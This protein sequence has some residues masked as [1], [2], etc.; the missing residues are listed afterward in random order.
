MS[1]LYPIA[2]WLSA[3][4]PAVV[5]LYLRRQ[6]RRTQTVSTLLFWQRAVAAQ[7]HQRFLGRLRQPWS[8][9][10][11][12]LILVLLILAAAQLR[13]GGTFEPRSTV[14]VI[15][16]RARMQA[17]DAFSKAR[18][19]ALAIASGAGPGEEVA[20]IGAEISPAIVSS[21]SRDPKHLR[22]ELNKLTPSDGGGDFSQ[23]VR[24]AQNLLRS[25]P[26]K[27]RLVAISDRTDP[28]LIDAEQIAVGKSGSNL[29]IIAS[30]A[31]PVPSSPQTWEIFTRVAN[32]SDTA[33]T[34]EISLSLDGRLFDARRLPLEAGATASFVTALPLRDTGKGLVETVLKSSDAMKLDD[35]A[36]T[37]LPV[38]GKTQVLLITTG[39][40]FLESALKA[41]PAINLEV[42]APETWKPSMA[43]AFAVVAFDGRP[44]ADVP[45]DSQTGFL[46][47][48][49]S[50]SG[51]A[52]K[53]TQTGEVEI[54]DPKSPLLRNTNLSSALFPTS[55]RL[56]AIGGT[57]WRV[58]DV[59]KGPAGP[60][61]TT[62]ERPGG[63][64]RRAIFSFGVA[65]SDLPLK[66]A[67]PILLSNTV[68]WLAGNEKDASRDI[69]AG[70]VLKMEE[71]LAV[72]QTGSS[73]TLRKA[74]F[75]EVTDKD[76][77]R[78][79]AV[80]ISAPEESDFRL[81]SASGGVKAPMLPMA[82][83]LW[84]WMALAAFALLLAEWWL[85]H[86][87]VTE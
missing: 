1:F 56:P 39:N 43:N 30:S 67:F 72:A 65:D 7:P 32:F 75:Y 14:V 2:L 31:R 42:L 10:L 74:G 50:P 16:S 33:E 18:D 17:G 9:L 37:A 84:Q 29:A 59:V 44:P 85:H 87:R 82:L 73:R 41:N 68:Q 20:I 11:Q 69:A 23:S 53:V 4:L 34:A 86:R 57:D 79:V 46:F 24:L 47:F 66:A 8:L 54:S 78:W 35:R 26:G 19:A 80:N 38:G 55:L 40:P 49:G 77:T 3:A 52:E 71:S 62:L 64:L 25:R 51:P 60:L 22:E 12:L 13:I 70:S 48:G 58:D 61:I 36:Y 83:S 5:L 28:K 21:F 63:G 6:K 27:T 81:A 76:S 45:M 15:D